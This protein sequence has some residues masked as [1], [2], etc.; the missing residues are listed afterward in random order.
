MHAQWAENDEFVDCLTDCFTALNDRAIECKEEMVLLREAAQ[1]TNG[2]LTCVFE[3]H[4]ATVQST[5]TDTETRC[6]ARRQWPM[7]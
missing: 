2:T 4:S 7:L 1:E 6:G 5:R 3:E